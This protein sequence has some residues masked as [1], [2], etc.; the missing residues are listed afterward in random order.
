VVA[1]WR[2][3]S[4]LVDSICFNIAARKSLYLLRISITCMFRNALMLASAGCSYYRR[5]IVIFVNA[6]RTGLTKIQSAK[7]LSEFF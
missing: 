3:P 4:S 5:L 2:W 7:V 1:G 6:R